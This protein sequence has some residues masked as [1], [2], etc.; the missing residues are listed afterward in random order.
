VM[1]VEA[2]KQNEPERKRFMMDWC[3]WGD[4]NSHEPCGPADFKS[5]AYADSA[6]AAPGVYA[7]K[8]IARGSCGSHRTAKTYLVRR[9]ANLARSSS[10]VRSNAK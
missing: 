9:G 6:T 2:P 8:R 10:E 5:A 7:A 4:L 3:G 1:A